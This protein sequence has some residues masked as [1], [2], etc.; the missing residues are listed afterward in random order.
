MLFRSVFIVPAKSTHEISLPSGIYL[1]RNS[2]KV[3]DTLQA[4][5]STAGNTPSVDLTVDYKDE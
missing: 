3:Y 1:H 4:E 5:L 2:A